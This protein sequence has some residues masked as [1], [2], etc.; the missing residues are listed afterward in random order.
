MISRQNT[1]DCGILM[2]LLISL[3]AIPSNL[4]AQTSAP[5]LLQPA[6]MPS[7]QSMAPM[8]SSV[9]FQSNYNVAPQQAIMSQPQ[10]THQPPQIQPYPTQ[11]HYYPP[12][13]QAASPAPNYYSDAERMVNSRSPRRGD[14]MATKQHTLL[15][16]RRIYRNGTTPQP[17]EL[18]G[19]WNG[20]NKGI[21]EIAGYAQ[22]IK[23]IQFTANGQIFGDN[24]QVSQVKP[25]QVRLDGWQPNFDYRTSDYER[26]GKFH[27]QPANGRGFFGHGA[28]L[29]Y[30]DGGNPQGDPARLLEDQVVIVDGNHMIGRAVAKFGP[31]KIPLAY[32]VLERR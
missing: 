9:P 32:F 23:D 27:V 15:Q 20:V 29:S 6:Y 21:V 24:I 22:F 2:I 4:Q 11:Q 1:R 7:A 18:V 30:A 17:H 10:V 31:F 5:G 8:V 25:G 28:T 3:F 19:Q 12:T 13:Q 14:L 26:R 16:Y